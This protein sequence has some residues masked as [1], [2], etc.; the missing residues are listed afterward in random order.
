MCT[1]K[2][3]VWKRLRNIFYS[4]TCVFLQLHVQ[5]RVYSMHSCM[6]RCTVDLL[7]TEN[8]CIF[9]KVTNLYRAAN[10][11]LLFMYSMDNLPVRV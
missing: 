6:F 5:V 4:F 9:I 8:I 11:V 1:G 7:F 10:S 3:S 2:I